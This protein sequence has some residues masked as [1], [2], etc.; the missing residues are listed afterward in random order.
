MQERDDKMQKISVIIPTYNRADKIL[1][2]VNSVLRQTYTNIEVIVVDDGSTDDTKNVVESIED[3]RVR[4]I[5]LLENGGASVARNVGVEHASGNIIAFEDSDDLWYANKLELQMEYWKLHP[6]F[7]MI[8]SQYK[9]HLSETT[10]IAPNPE[11]YGEMEG[12]IFPWLLLRNSIGTPTMIMYKECFEEIGGFDTEM[13]SLEDW[14]FA[15]RFAEQFLIGY[16]EQ[17]LVN[18]FFSEGG[19]S[20]STSAYYES[21]CKM[22]AEYKEYMIS[23][24]IFDNIVND[25]FHRAEERGVLA[26][27]KSM[28]L[29]YLSK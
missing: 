4:Y 21:R 2:S 24:G 22:I 27:V 8:Y 29:T 13:R 25:L 26:V 14:D 23:Y 1:E 9:M 7:S 3:E 15:I 10:C 19:V 11:W 20:S 16:V 5:R 17:P 18:A 6:E 12:D 28:L